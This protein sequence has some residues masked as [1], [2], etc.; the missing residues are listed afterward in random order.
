M[1]SCCMICRYLSRLLGVYMIQGF[2]YIGGCRAVIVKND[3]PCLGDEL[4]NF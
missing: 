2:K 4:Q 1:P 3:T